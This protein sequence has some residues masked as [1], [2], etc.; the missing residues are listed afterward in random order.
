MV[1]KRVVGILLECFLVSCFVSAFTFLAQLFASSFRIYISK[2]FVFVQISKCESITCGQDG[3]PEIYVWDI[4]ERK[5]LH[6]VSP[7]ELVPPPKDSSLV[8]YHNYYLTDS[9]RHLVVV[10]DVPKD[11]K[12]DTTKLG[13]FNVESGE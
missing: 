11:N 8:H 3:G 10:L 5:L 4:A 9:G 6:I 12:P 1:G 7:G 2:I 13:V